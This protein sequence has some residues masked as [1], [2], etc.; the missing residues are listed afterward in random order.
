LLFCLC[1]ASILGA[2][3]ASAWFAVYARPAPVLHLA[4]ADDNTRVALG[5]HL[6]RL[7]CASCHGRY[8][9]G[10]PLWQVND[11]DVGRRA[12]AHDE[13]GHT[14]QHSDEVLFHMTKYGR[15][16]ETPAKAVS[17]MPAFKDILTDA[18]ILSVI[19]FIKRR[20]PL[21]LRVSQAMLNP[22]QAGM[23][24]DASDVAWTLPPTC[25]ATLARR[26]GSR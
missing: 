12:P 20:W 17:F 21:G 2:A 7:H 6:Y 10:Q 23:P 1:A 13:S 19:A 11:R 3:A 25:M 24:P 4:D 15:F 5:K 22:G 16:D 18:D 26:T 9:Q 14:W 8:L